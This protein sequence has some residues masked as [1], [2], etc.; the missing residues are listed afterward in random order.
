MAKNIGRRKVVIESMQL[1]K[2]DMAS[3]FLLLSQLLSQVWVRFDQDD[4]AESSAL[5]ATRKSSRKAQ[6][7][8]VTQLSRVTDQG[9]ARENAWSLK[10]RTE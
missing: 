9:R 4:Q 2:L 3:L 6:R 5:R 8:R 10:N 7:S 1:I